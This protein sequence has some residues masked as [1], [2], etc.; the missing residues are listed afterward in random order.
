MVKTQ[1]GVVG[2]VMGADVRDEKAKNS[3]RLLQGTFFHTWARKN[4]IRSIPSFRTAGHFTMRL[5]RRIRCTRP[6]SAFNNQIP[7]KLVAANI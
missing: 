6:V 5:A 4:E 2:W 3:F 7:G 1:K